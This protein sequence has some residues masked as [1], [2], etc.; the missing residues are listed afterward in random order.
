MSAYQFLTSMR[1]ACA[2]A[3]F[4][5][6]TAAAAAVETPKPDGA[7]AEQAQKLQAQAAEIDRLKKQVEE[8]EDE[9][10]ELSIE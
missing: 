6:L 3:V 1:A 8:L 4:V 5:G 7:C 10:D 9:I 2:A